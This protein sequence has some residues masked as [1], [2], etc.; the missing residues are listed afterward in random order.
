MLLALDFPVTVIKYPNKSN[1]REKGFI[2]S[3]RL[4]YG[5]PRQ[6]RLGAAGHTPSSIKMQ[7]LMN[8]VL[9]Q[10]SA[11]HTLRNLSLEMV[12]PTEGRSSHLSQSNQDNLPLTTS[13]SSESRVRWQFPVTG[14]AFCRRAE[15]SAMME[16]FCLLFR[17]G[18]EPLAV[19]SLKLW[20]VLLR[21]W[22]VYL[23][24][25]YFSFQITACG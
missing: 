22:S 16:M 7:R 19:L 14:T 21:N 9:I 13:S 2:L 11:F 23:I 20:L 10:L 12:P 18:T 3:R 5:P 1:L 8:S 25:S 4:R 15:S 24:F 17:C 6:Q